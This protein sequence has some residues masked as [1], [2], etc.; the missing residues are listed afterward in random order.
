MNT[1]KLN[2]TLELINS[3]QLSQTKNNI[4]SCLEELTKSLNCEYYLFA[5]INPKSMIKSDVKILD[6]YPL[7]W[8]N[9]YDEAN[10]ITDD[11]IVDYSSSHHS[12]INWSIFEK[13]TKKNTKVNVI[14]E[15]K[16]SGLYSGF[17]FPIH[18][19]NGGF[20]MISFAN[21]EKDKHIDKLFL[22][23]CMNVPLILPSLLDSNKRITEDNQQENINLTKR[24]KECLIWSCEG[25]STWE[26]SKILN[27][28]ERTV[29]FHLTNS[30]IKLSAN[31]RCQSISKAILTRSMSPLY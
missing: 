8:R 30:Q 26:I 9:Y 18:T 20:G 4:R 23:A 16:I 11:P 17:S 6:N 28:S 31:N 10:L 24:E 29:T 12:P 25:K 19:H 15:A 27:C 21:S 13:Q 2:T 7:Y 3:I 14:E 22:N 1:K 5:I